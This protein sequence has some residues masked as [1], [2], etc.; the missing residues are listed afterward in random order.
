MK[1]VCEKTCYSFKTALKKKVSMLDLSTVGYK[2][3]NPQWRDINSKIVLKSVNRNA[4][5]FLKNPSEKIGLAKNNFNAKF[6]PIF[7]SPQ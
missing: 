7:E 2:K 3:Q 6:F 4:L 1:T 5:F